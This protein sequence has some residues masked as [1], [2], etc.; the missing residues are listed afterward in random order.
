MGFW[1]KVTIK[2][3][4]FYQHSGLIQTNFVDCNFEPSCSNF[5]KQALYD[6]GFF[7]GIKLSFLRIM[8]CNQRDISR[9]INDPVP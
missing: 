6:H 3:I 8:R 2:A 4:S 1:A 7:S 5:A 9:K